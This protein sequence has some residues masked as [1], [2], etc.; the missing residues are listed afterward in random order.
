MKFMDGTDSTILTMGLPG[1][2]VFI[3]VL[4]GVQKVESDTREAN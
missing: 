3:V 1:T 4:S 2:L